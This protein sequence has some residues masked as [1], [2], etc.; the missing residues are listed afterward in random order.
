MARF[1][2]NS[3][4][5]S[6][7]ARVL[8]NH[9]WNVQLIQPLSCQSKTDE[10]PAILRHEVD[11]LRRNFACGNRQIAFV[12]PVLVINHNDDS[13][14]AHILYR[15]FNAVESQN[16][17]SFFKPIIKPSMTSKITGN[18]RITKELVSRSPSLNVNLSLLAVPELQSLPSM[19]R[20][21]LVYLFVGLYV[22]TLGPPGMLWTCASG[23][24]SLLYGLARFCIRAAGWIC[25]VRVDV[26]GR[27]KI[28]PG[29]TYVFLSNHQ[30]N[31]DGPVLVHAIP[32]DWS[33][34]IKK[35]M[36]RLPVF[37]LVLKQ[38]Q[39]IPIE[40]SNPK[41]AHTGIE[42]GAKLLSAGK[43]FLAFPE[44]TRSR[45]GRLGEFKKGVFIMA[46]KAQAPIVPVT[47]LNSAKVQPPGRYGIRPGHIQVIFHQPIETKGMT[48]EDRNRLV[49]L[50]RDAISSALAEPTQKL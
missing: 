29:V 2:R 7:F 34:L 14:L 5:R 8:A 49:Q 22:L 37:S 23:D 24:S 25:G 16:D 38:V 46:I 26:Q 21:T 35:E 1:N 10:S 3:K 47:I 40:R 45:D 39:F 17:T 18:R 13:T 31:F 11:L 4:S 27:E 36:M 20:A 42:R 12:F 33:G 41:E 50:T 32:R 19:I 44:G 30:G 28:T 43:S 9:H 15:F 6:E 48:M